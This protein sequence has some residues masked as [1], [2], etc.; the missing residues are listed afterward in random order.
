MPGEDTISSAAKTVRVNNS[1][2]TLTGCPRHIFNKCFGTLVDVH[3]I[4]LPLGNVYVLYVVRAISA[5]SA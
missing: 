4:R 2:F 5:C 3:L 1:P